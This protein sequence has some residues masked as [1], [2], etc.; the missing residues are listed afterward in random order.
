[1]VGGAQLDVV[2]VT[3]N[4]LIVAVMVTENDIALAA[5]FTEREFHQSIFG[6]H[7][8]HRG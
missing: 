1:M 3:V 4:F 2:G 8:R 6:C 7:Q 5:R